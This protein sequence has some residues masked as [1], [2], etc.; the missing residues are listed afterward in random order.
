MKKLILLFSTTLICTYFFYSC[1][2]SPSSTK[3]SLAGIGSFRSK[4]TASR[5]RGEYL[6]WHVMGCMDCHSKRDFSKFSGPVVAGTE[7]MG[8]EKFGPEVGLP[9]TVYAR[10]ITPAGIGTWSDDD[11]IKAIT[12]G[13]SKNGDTLFPLMP[14]LAYSKMSRQDLTDIIKYI[15]TLKPIENKVPGRELFIPIS[16][17]IPPQ[18]PNP[19]LDKN[20]K[21][22]TK[23][24]IKYGEYLFT[25]ASC[26]DCHTPRTRGVP[27]F[28]RLA[29]GGNI[30][31]HE[32]FT[33]HI[34]NI[35]PDTSGI[36]LWT[37]KMFLQKFRANSAEEYVNRDPAKFNSY[38]PWSLFGKMKDE[39]LKAIYSYLRTLKPVQGRV[40]P[41]GS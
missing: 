8:G 33:V 30:F 1:D 15:R 26:S 14:Y 32:T 6:A 37:E 23:D 31:K 21:P 22:E 24:K 27:D 12:R 5:E 20:H 3:A 11:L 39:D 28:T 9:G 41:W 13:I 40:Y 34:P 7:G 16:M 29:G 25:M 17:A 2:Q 18:L 4:E 35:T 38:M 19:D 10:N 36:G